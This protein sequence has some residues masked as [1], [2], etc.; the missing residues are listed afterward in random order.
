MPVIV[1]RDAL[2]IVSDDPNPLTTVPGLMAAHQWRG[3]FVGYEVP[4]P[5][6]SEV[7]AIFSAADSPDQLAM[8]LDTLACGV[9]Q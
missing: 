1:N 3:F 6:S 4:L 8:A 5:L 9:S 2:W 7:K